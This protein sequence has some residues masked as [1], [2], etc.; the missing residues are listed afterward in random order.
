MLT[1]PEHGLY[2]APKNPAAYFTWICPNS[3][4]YRDF[5]LDRLQKII[6]TLDVSNIYI[7]NSDAQLC[8]NAR[9]GC[10]YQGT[11]GKRYTSFNLR[12]TRELAKRVYTLLKNMRPDGRVIRHMSAKPVA[13]VVGFADMLVDGE[14]YNKTVALDESH[15]NIFSP[16]MFRASFCGKLWG[17]PQFFIPQFTRVIPWHNPGRWNA[18]KT[19]AAREKQM[20][21]IRH[22]KGWFLVHDTQIF[23]LF[24]V[25][26]ND[27]EKIKERFGLRNETRFIS[28]ASPEK[29]WQASSGVLVS[30]YA[31][32]GKLMLILVNNGRNSSVSVTLNKAELKKLG[33]EKLAF[34]NAENGKSVP[35][36][37]NKINIRLAAHD[38]MILW[39]L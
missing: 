35:V 21:K 31:D 5:Y 25:K 22:F 13:P 16:D 11:D 24:G 30:G 32:N 17:I 34:V 36:N 12:G 3:E 23:Q 26:V 19:P 27:V 15:F 18:W 9:H 10:G 39:N 37:G 20:D 28:Y 7:D 4:E 6:T 33:V 14:L 8:D 38:Y 1:P 2:G 29:P